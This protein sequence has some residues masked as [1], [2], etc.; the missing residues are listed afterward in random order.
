MCHQTSIEFTINVLRYMDTRTVVE[1]EPQEKPFNPGSR[2][3]KWN[4]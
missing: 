1:L 4:S 2:N 3:G